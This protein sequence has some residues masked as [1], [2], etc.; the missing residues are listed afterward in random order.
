MRHIHHYDTDLE[1]EVRMRQLL[2]VVKALGPRVLRHH[3][4][5]CTSR[6]R[7]A[8]RAALHAFVDAQPCDTVTF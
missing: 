1:V 2:V 6:S 4:T 3:E 8:R 5:H 7:C